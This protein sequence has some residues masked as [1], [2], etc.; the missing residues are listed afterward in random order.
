MFTHVYD[1]LSWF[2]TN[3]LIPK[4]GPPKQK[5]L[6][7]P[8]NL[9]PLTTFT[10]SPFVF[11][12]LTPKILSIPIVSLYKHKFILPPVET[13]RQEPVIIEKDPVTVK[14]FG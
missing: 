3:I 14:H 7:P 8:L 9:P 11:F 12:S 1:D 2:K 6:A 4:F 13:K 5:I 10:S